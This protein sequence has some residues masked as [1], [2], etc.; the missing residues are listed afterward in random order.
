[1]A[2]KAEIRS[3]FIGRLFAVGVSVGFATA[4]TRMNWVKT[5]EFPNLM[6]LDQILILTGGLIASLLS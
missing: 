2:T 6:E 4:I 1:M 5:G 3:D